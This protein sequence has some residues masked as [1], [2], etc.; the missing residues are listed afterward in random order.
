[1]VDHRRLL[2]TVARLHCRACAHGRTLR[3]ADEAMND[4]QDVGARLSSDVGTTLSSLSSQHTSIGAS[5]QFPGLHVRRVCQR[6][7]DTFCEVHDS[8]QVPLSL[9][10]GRLPKTY[11]LMYSPKHGQIAPTHGPVMSRS[12]EPAPGP[13]HGCSTVGFCLTAVDPIVPFPSP[14]F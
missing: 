14:R 4:R 1:M 10:S 5:F 7:Q 2:E 12:P 6:V 8:Y 3:G 13:C 9:P 11:T